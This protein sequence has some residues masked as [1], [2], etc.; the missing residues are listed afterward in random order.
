MLVAHPALAASSLVE[1]LAYARSR[2]QAV[3]FAT[4]G[5]GTNNH[6]AM[7]LF[8]H[9]TGINA[10]AVH[11]K[12]GGQS[13]LALLSGEVNV[14][15]G[16]MSGVLP[17]VKSGKL[18]AYVVTSRQRFPSVPDVPTA[19]ESGLNDLELEFWIGVL[20]PARTP[21]YL[22]S[23][24]NREFGEILLTP[25]IKAALLAH[26]A[27]ATPGTRAEFAMYIQRES[28]KMKKLVAITGMRAD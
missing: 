6:I 16:L 20:A 21:G 13:S 23:R 11:Y 17:H 27:Q 9:A 12:G 15:F 24:L 8:R 10:I 18:K 1:F 25:R 2:P 5:P 7:E 19:A 28:D 22:V 14:G 3:Q 26:G 4:A